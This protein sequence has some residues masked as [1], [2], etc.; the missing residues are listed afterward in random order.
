[1][2][3]NIAWKEFEALLDGEAME[4]IVTD[5]FEQWYV[6]LP[7]AQQKSVFVGVTKL[8]LEGV[9]LG[10]PS[11]SAIEG[12]SFALRELRVQSQGKPLRIFY[13]FD[14]ARD[15]VLILGGDKTSDARFYERNIPIA[16]ALWGDY[17]KEKGF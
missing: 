16:T 14:P 6:D 3:Y 9:N 12:A 7:H 11:S 13:A 4:V 5:E 10:Y 17:L 8:E 2:G 1:M 15:A